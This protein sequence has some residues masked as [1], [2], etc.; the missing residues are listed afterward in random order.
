MVSS[1]LFLH[2]LCGFIGLLAFWVA[3]LSKKGSGLHLRFGKV[4]VLAAYGIALT[5]V[6][7][8][9]SRILD[10]LALGKTLTS[11][12]D[13]FA[14][15]LFLSYLAL[16]TF[17]NTW[18][19]IAVVRTK[20]NPQAIDTRLYRTITIAQG[21]GSLI[22]MLFSVIYK[23]NITALLLGLS[24]IGILNAS[25]MVNYPKRAH[26][27]MQWLYTHLGSI[28]GAGIA[29]H[30]AFFVFG[31]NRLGILDLPGNLQLIPWLAPAAIGI[32]LANVWERHYRKKFGD[33]PNK[34]TQKSKNPSKIKAATA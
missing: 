22:I 20:K 32:P 29:F 18:M 31:A 23:P 9:S 14:A 4:F 21:I 6:V 11:H 27:K 7:V 2:V 17:G 16:T 5:A 24:P 26:V 13:S 30:T 28:L 3:V 15:P 34:V 25:M 19:A 8:V 12:P 1:V 10:A 33:L